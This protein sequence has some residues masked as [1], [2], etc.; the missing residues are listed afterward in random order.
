[1]EGAKMYRQA[2]RKLMFFAIAFGILLLS[3]NTQAETI[4]GYEELISLLAKGGSQQEQ[5]DVQTELERAEAE[6]QG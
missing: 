1:M 2:F 5:T 3:N 6:A 4:S